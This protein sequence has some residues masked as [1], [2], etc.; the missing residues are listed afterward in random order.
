M[1]DRAIGKG[2]L[3]SRWGLVGIVALATSLAGHAA[4]IN[5]RL[6]DEI[7][8]GIATHW[9]KCVITAENDQEL[10]YRTIHHPITSMTVPQSQV[11]GLKRR[12]TAAESYQENFKKL[13]EAPE[14]IAQLMSEVYEFWPKLLPGAISDLERYTRQRPHYECV[15]I[16]GQMYLSPALG[17]KVDPD[18]ALS[19]ARQ[20]EALDNTKAEAYRLQYWGH[21]L[22]GQ[23]PEALAAIEKAHKLAPERPEVLVPWVKAQV[24]SGQ[25][26]QALKA[27]EEVLKQNDAD[28]NA[29][30]CR[31][32]IL[33]AL[34]KLQEAELSL[35]KAQLVKSEVA[36]L[37][38]LCSV[39]Y[40][41]GRYDQAISTAL[42]V[43]A[44]S[45]NS[46]AAAGAIATLALAR[47]RKEGPAAA[48]AARRLLAEA[49]TLEPR[50]ARAYVALGMLER[51]QGNPEAALE[52]FQKAAR[53]NPADAYAQYCHGHALFAAGNH[54][55]AT[56]AF[57]EAARLARQD[58][59]VQRALGACLLLT[60]EYARAQ[61]TF[62]EALRAVPERSDLHSGLGMALLQLGEIEPAYRS[63]AKA[64]QLD[65]QNIEALA[66]LAYIENQRRNAERTESYLRR[67][68]AV[69]GDMAWALEHLKKVYAER[70]LI[71]DYAGFGGAELPGWLSPLSS[72]KESG[73]EQRPEEGVFRI[74]GNCKRSA[75]EAG[76]KSRQQ[77]AGF[78]RLSADFVAPDNVPYFAG[79]IVASTGYSFLLKFGK[80][81]HNKVGYTFKDYAGPRDWIEFDQWPKSGKVHLA[82][83]LADPRNNEFHL[84]LGQNRLTDAEG[85]PVQVRINLGTRNMS[86]LDAGAGVA[87]MNAGDTVEV[88]FD[89]LIVLRKAEKGAEGK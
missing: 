8:V 12:M 42:Q 59:D 75:R 80:T 28:G 84:Y 73:L 35:G 19:C 6:Y 46:A 77:A 27:V 18:K 34:G 69:Q 54:P 22:K 9:Q 3:A 65:A 24:E 20:A 58:I 39:Y 51:E 72:L 74:S 60:K 11:R 48:E 44:Q 63:L 70:E 10:T 67:I 62:E 4:L 89:N 87:D 13:Q 78:L 76:L 57:Q 31:G 23:S 41:T 86:H 25:A 33:L 1:S 83:E 40:L 5:E 38:A 53:A 55:A 26:E 66:G 56:A 85:K 52:N 36:R 29:H 82:L 30:F 17:E 88:T 79:L 14:T 7:L 47:L 81:V 49:F 16:L 45:D 37:S 32:L 43:R 21:K 2:R 64:L 68:L 50:N 71:I 15:I 61:Q